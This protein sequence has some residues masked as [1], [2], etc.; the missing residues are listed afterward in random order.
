MTDA[1][2]NGWNLDERDERLYPQ[3]RKLILTRPGAIDLEVIVHLAYEEGRLRAAITSTFAP[4][5]Q[6]H[7][8]PASPEVTQSASWP[9]CRTSRAIIRHASSLSSTTSTVAIAS[10]FP[11]PVRLRGIGLRARV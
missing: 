11:G 8:G 3:E 4:P 10:S 2:P 6:R 9:H 5:D 1:P 7:L